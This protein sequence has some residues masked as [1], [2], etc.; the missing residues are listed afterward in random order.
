MITSSNNT[1]AT[2][3]VQF[4]NASEGSSESSLNLKEDN[5]IVLTT[6]LGFILITCKDIVRAEANR[7]YCNF[8][9]KDGTKLRASRSLKFYESKLREWNFI[10][11]H[12]S[13]MVN[14]THVE[15]YIK[16]KG[17]SLV[18]SDNSMVPVSIR[19]KHRLNRVFIEQPELFSIQK[20]IVA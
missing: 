19:K 12:K 1:N 9:L 11:V 15:G 13:F 10:K 8:H 5:K 2:S 17:A 18:L 7:A 6:R 14:L 16:G 4:V 20:S 3:S